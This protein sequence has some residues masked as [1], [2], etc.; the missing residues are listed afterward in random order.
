MTRLWQFAALGL[1]LLATALAL[2]PIELQR[3]LFDDA[4]AKGDARLLVLLAG[5]YLAVVALHQVAKFALGLVQNWLSESALRYTRDHLWGLRGAEPPANGNGR[6]VTAIL[7]TE[8]PALAGFAGARPSQA[9][10]DLAMLAGALVYM[11]VVEPRVALVG[12]LLL[13]PQVALAPVI[14]R[15]LNRLV[16]A[17]LRLIRRYAAAAGAERPPEAKGMRRRVSNLYDMRLRFV[18]WKLV[19]KAL[20]NFLNAAAPLAVIAAGGFMVISGETSLGVVV[21]FVGGFSRLGDPARQLIAFY[22]EAAEANV[23]H[24]MIARWMSAPDAG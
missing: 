15:R 22:R 24:R 9:L 18:F 14:Q 17:R 10:A 21:A 1:A 5:V 6:D 23:R 11:F 3:R 12:L 16:E 2:A 13:L 19:M 20:L 8:L 7:T 4:I